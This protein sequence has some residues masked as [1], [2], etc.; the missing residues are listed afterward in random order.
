MLKLNLNKDH[1][2]NFL[3]DE[4]LSSSLKLKEK[5]DEWSIRIND[6]F[7]KDTKKR[8]GISLKHFENGN[9]KVIFN[10]FKSSAILGDDY[11]GDFYKFVKLIKHFD[12]YKEAKQWFNKTYLLQNDSLKDILN[13]EH[14]TNYNKNE[15]ILYWSDKYKKLDLNKKVHKDYIDYLLKRKVDKKHIENVKIFI[16]RKNKRLIFPVYENEKLIFYTKRSIV[17]NTEPWIKASKEDVFPIWNLENISDEE[18]YIFEGIFDAIHILNGVAILG[19]AFEEVIKKIVKRN[20]KKYIIVLDNDEV[21]KKNKIKIA[22]ILRDEYNKNVFIYNYKGIA[23]QY[24]DFG[25]MKINNIP[26]ELETRVLKFDFKTEALI[27]LG[28]VI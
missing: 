18:I 14:K 9:S 13:S 1:V 16:D 7:I 19:S 20:F 11:H 5:N 17:P 25:E 26:F 21:G 15:E 23:E 22:K 4:G 12:T 10:G 27:K 8:L 2:L 6:P 24:K 28:K 3:Q